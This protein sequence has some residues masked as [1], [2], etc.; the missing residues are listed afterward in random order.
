[1]EE[2]STAISE[3]SGIVVVNGLGQSNSLESISVLHCRMDQ[4]FYGQSTLQ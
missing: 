3:L 2:L 1:M 4:I